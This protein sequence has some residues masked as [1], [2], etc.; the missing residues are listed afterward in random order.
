MSRPTPARRLV[1]AAV[2]VVPIVIVVTVSWLI[3]EAP[4]PEAR[5]LVP[6]PVSNP[7]PDPLPADYVPA[8]TGSIALNGAYNRWDEDVVIRGP[9]P[10]VLRRTYLAGDTRSRAFGIGWSHDGEQFLVGDRG[11]FQ[12]VSIVLAS[13]TQVRFDRVSPGTAFNEGVFVHTQSPTKYNG[14]RL[15]WLGNSWGV[16]LLDDEYL[17][18]ER[19]WLPKPRP[20]GLVEARDANGHVTRL[21]RDRQGLLQ[22]MDLEDEW[23]AF[24][25]DR[26]DRVVRAWSSQDDEVRY[27]YDVR[28]RLTRVTAKNGTTQVYTY[29]DRD[30]LMTATAPQISIENDYDGSSRCIRQTVQAQGE[31]QPY[32]L[33]FDYAVTD[34]RVVESRETKPDGT[35]TKHVLNASG[36]PSD[37]TAGR[38]SI[39]LWEV[40]YVRDPD[41]NVIQ[42][43][44]VTCGDRAGRPA[45][46]SLKVSPGEEERAEEELASTYCRSSLP[47]ARWSSGERPFDLFR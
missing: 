29:N 3:G 37:K 31:P 17:E 40:A 18:F 14:A 23:I 12:W 20:C 10:L 4:S 38:G 26:G 28:G 6:T 33:Q 47:P 1:T 45:S 36:Y 30:L 22:R 7:Q 15:G 27:T 9:V 44:T 43:L 11:G 5:L 25:Y 19:C 41:S 8:H 13:G 24:E 21:T 46:H 34:G 35:W 42:R 39:T 2:V 16:R 32:V